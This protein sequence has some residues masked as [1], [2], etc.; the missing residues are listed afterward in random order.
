MKQK[1]PIDY[2]KPYGSSSHYIT[3]S[4]IGSSSKLKPTR[5]RKPQPPRVTTTTD[6]PETLIQTSHE[7]SIA[8]STSTTKIS[9]AT[10]KKTTTTSTSTTLFP[11]TTTTTT[12]EI[13]PTTKKSLLGS[14]PTVS[15]VIGNDDGKKSTQCGVPP[16]FPR[17]ETRI[18]G[19]KDAP[20]GRW[21]WQVS[22]RRTSFFG[23]SSTHRCGGA[24]L[25]ENWIATAGHCVDE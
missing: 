22:V 4:D 1:N 2:A 20:F 13:P 5:K 24:V 12:T 18:V 16:L 9:Q 3:S 15:A 7:T 14:V 19:G 6:Y 23:F 21:P 17:P 10:P 11:T 8:L 25:N